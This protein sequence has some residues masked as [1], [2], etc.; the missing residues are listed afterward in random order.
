M[1]L[2]QE[3]RIALRDELFENFKSNLIIYSCNDSYRFFSKKKFITDIEKNSLI[4]KYNL[5]VEQFR[6]EDEAIYCLLHNDDISNHICPICNTNIKLFYSNKN[7]KRK[8]YRETCGSDICIRKSYENNSLAPKKNNK[9]KNTISK[10]Q[11]ISKN[12]KNEENSIT[13]NY[14][15]Q[16][17]SSLLSSLTDKELKSYYY[18][19]C[20]NNTSMTSSELQ[21]KEFLESIG[22]IEN[23]K[24]DENFE[25]NNE[26]EINF[27]LDKYKIGFEINDIANHTDKVKTDK[28]YHLD[29]SLKYYK[30]GIHIIH[31]W[32]WE[33]VR[34]D[35]WNRLSNWIINL[36]NNKK[37]RV[38][39]R[40]T[41]IRTVSLKEEKIFLNNYHLQGYIRSEV[42]LGL[43]YDN[44]L[45]QL[46]SFGKPRYNKN[47]EYELIR[48]CTLYGY[49]IIGGA[50]KLLKNFIKNYNPKSLISY[51]NLDKFSGKIY[52]KIGFK[53]LK[54][55][56]PFRIWFDQETQRIVTEQSLLA[57]SAK[58]NKLIENSPYQSV[59][60]CGQN[61]YI[62]NF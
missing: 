19:N 50:E 41:E 8:E 58:D 5:Y 56:S 31:I 36:L 32:E 22:F 48:L 59:Y 12:E 40:K 35:L 4:E 13:I 62:L 27:Y 54:R 30:K 60:N 42:C 37:S 46:M 57:L 47:Y 25:K 44:Q 11:K 20:D 6:T 51:C 55:N 2:T 34:E 18:N 7:S 15:Q 23:N 38:F 16:L 26:S 33:L 21:F 28:R 52:K 24:N 1:K 9:I 49:S 17:Q 43:Y 45:I 61:V 14:Q 53:L 29:K 3:D 10:A 39:A